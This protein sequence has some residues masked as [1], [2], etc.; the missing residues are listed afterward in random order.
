MIMFGRK[1]MIVLAALASVGTAALVPTSASAF[2]GHGGFGG[3]HG[4]FGGYRGGFGGYHGYGG[5]NY[6]SYWNCCYRP[7]GYYQSSYSVP[8]YSSYSAPSYA[9]PPPS[10]AVTQKVYVEG[11]NNAGPPPVGPVGPP[12]QP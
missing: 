3:Y 9:P 7:Y 5:W 2:G 12:P 10:L 1:S 4:G 6:R 8:S 11:N